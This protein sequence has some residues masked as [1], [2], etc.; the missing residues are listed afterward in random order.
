MLA[1]EIPSATIFAGAAAE[2]HIEDLR[3]ILIVSFETAVER[4]IEP[5]VALGAILEW[6]GQECARLSKAWPPATGASHHAQ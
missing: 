4:G 6:A 3:A 5:S 2:R 1:G